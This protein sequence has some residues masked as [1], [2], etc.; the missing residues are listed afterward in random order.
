AAPWGRDL[1]KSLQDAE[2]EPDQQART[3]RYQEINRRLMAEYLP[4]IPISHSPPAIVVN[5]RVKGLIPSPLT[6]EEFGPVSIG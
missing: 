4:A 5:K 3:K 6:Q 2:S 1:V